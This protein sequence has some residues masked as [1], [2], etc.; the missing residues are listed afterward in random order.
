MRCNNDGNQKNRCQ[1]SKQNR[2]PIDALV[3]SVHMDIV[4]AVQLFLYMAFSLFF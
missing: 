2:H 4:Y 3:S 1:K